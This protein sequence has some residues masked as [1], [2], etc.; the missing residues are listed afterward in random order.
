MDNTQQRAVQSD[1]EDTKVPRIAADSDDGGVDLAMTVAA[2][3]SGLGHETRTDPDVFRFLSLPAEI[4]LKIYRLLFKT[5]RPV[6][7]QVDTIPAR[8]RQPSGLPPGVVLSMVLANKQLANEVTHF[9][10]SQNAFRLS[11][12]YHRDWLARIG[13]RNSNLLREVILVGNGQPT[14]AAQQLSSMLVTLWKRAFGSLRRLIVH[15]EWWTPLDADFIPR[16]LL[17][18]G[19]S[20]TWKRFPELQRIDIDIPHFHAPVAYAAIYMRL[21]VQTGV[22]ITARHRVNGWHL[23]VLHDWPR[24]YTDGLIWFR[25]DPSDLQEAVEKAREATK[26]SKLRKRRER[27]KALKARKAR[28]RREAEAERAGK[29]VV[30]KEVPPRLISD[31][32][33]Y[34]ELQIAKG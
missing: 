23:P 4:R 5:D 34:K 29:W 11:I 26:Q 27:W 16:R 6:C 2:P 19:A 30:V 22:L 3:G 7:P 8:E 24:F 1:N 25:V 31:F 28:E 13:R 32:T 12:R 18:V 9:L 14:L 15:G 17:E 21:C 20:R 33:A 10:Y